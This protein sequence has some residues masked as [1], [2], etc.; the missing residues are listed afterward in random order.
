M[1]P[2]TSSVFAMPGLRINGY[3]AI[4][5]RYPNIKAAETHNAFNPIDGW[6]QAK[7]AWSPP[8]APKSPAIEIQ[9]GAADWSV[10]MCNAVHYQPPSRSLSPSFSLS[11]PYV[12]TPA[13][14]AA[15]SNHYMLRYFDDGIGLLKQAGGG[16]ADER[17]NWRASWRVGRWRSRV[18]PPW[19][20]WPLRRR[21]YA[22]IRLHV[23]TLYTDCA[24]HSIYTLVLQGICT[25]R[26]F[27][28][29][30]P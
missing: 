2:H 21:R 3:R 10:T 26:P 18:L 17:I 6:I 11:L 1:G 28:E 12:A 5:A 25:Q 13:M 20:R 7:T 30:A 15:D 29:S 16:L 23:R 27:Y 14:C 24:A 9:I 19:R 4:S 8:L 22:C